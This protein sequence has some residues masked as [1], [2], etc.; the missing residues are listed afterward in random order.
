MLSCPLT[1]FAGLV[2]YKTGE[3]V[4]HGHLF[5]LCLHLDHLLGYSLLLAGTRLCRFIFFHI[6][7]N[8]LAQVFRLTYLDFDFFAAIT[9]LSFLILLISLVLGIISLRWFGRG[10][11]NY[12]TCDYK[13]QSI[14]AYIRGQCMR[15][16]A[17]LKQV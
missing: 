17:S 7:S 8:T 2:W 13:R 16:I 11:S 6:S 15:R 10:L 14:C 1:C 5:D 3:Q 12:R 4:A 9:T